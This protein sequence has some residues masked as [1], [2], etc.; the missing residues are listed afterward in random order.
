MALWNTRPLNSIGPN[1]FGKKDENDSSESL[2]ADSFKCPTCG[3]NL[4]YEPELSSMMCRNCGNVYSPETLELRGSLGIS[5]EHDYMGDSDISEDDK[6]R[7]EISCNSCGATLIADENTMSTM[8]PFCGSPALITRRMT[9]EFKPDY[10]VPF[11]IDKDQ[12][13]KIMR[14][15]LGSKKHTPRGFKTKSRLTGMTA[16]YVPFWLL[17]CGVNTEMSGTGKIINGLNTTIYEVNS[18]LTYYVKGVPFNASLNIA[19][20]LM[21]A[22]EPFDYRD[23]VRFESKYLQGFYADKYDQLPTEMT[24][25]I[26]KRI[27]R[28]SDSETELVSSKYSKY[29]VRSEKGLTR[30]S[31]I[32][33][34][35]CLLPVWFMTVEFDGRQYQFAINGQTGEA[36]GQ[37][38]TADSAD[39]IDKISSVFKGYFYLILLGV[40]VALPIA[41]AF[42]VQFSSSLSALK[43]ALI[44]LLGIIEV[45][46]VVLFF[47]MTSVNLLRGRISPKKEFKT[48][49][50]MNDYDKDPGL[51]SY[52]DSA[53]PSDIK[54]K[55][56]I[57]RHICKVTDS[58]GNIIG[59]R[60]VEV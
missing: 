3:S 37:V 21:E 47:I 18:T 17:D 39:I 28:F 49:Y 41:I 57:L 52:F 60:S 42:L 46:A 53:R 59:E 25:K 51:A 1:P 38:P 58:H 34:K 48:A 23:M 8:C 36:S 5:R 29:E 56:K 2:S 15:W 4:F 9:R 33:I 45:A 11:K 43:I 55:E 40:V 31:E 24:D 32:S 54:V 12:A 10:I 30:L 7:H 20:K 14:E 22:I 26:M 16:L 27:E 50:E 19:N 13:Q 6:K 44:T 35:Y